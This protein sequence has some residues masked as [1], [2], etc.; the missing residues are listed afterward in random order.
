MSLAA[1][2]RKVKRL[3]PVFSAIAALGDRV[4]AVYLVGGS[5]RDILLR[6]PGFDV[7]IAV[8]GDA[9]SFAHALAEP[10]GGR[11]TAHEKFGTAAVLYG[12]HE[13]VDVV[14]TRTEFYDAPAA[15]PSVERAA[16][17]EDLFRRDFTLNAMALSLKPADFGRLV[18]PFGGR[19][20]S[21]RARCGCS[22]PPRSSTTR[23][24]SS[25]RFATRPATGFAS[26]H[27]LIAR[28]H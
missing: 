21:R 25:A 2:L 20:D 7:D 5:V 16:I 13:R 22:Q 3:A 17:R 19:R 8:E 6:E 9:I 26:R 15:L 23:H 11:V 24:A 28:L 12:E 27:S 18:D 4:E 14:T 10:L 1:E